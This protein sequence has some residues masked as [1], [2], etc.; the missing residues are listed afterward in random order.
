[1][2]SS[3]SNESPETYH[4]QYTHNVIAWDLVA[5]CWQGGKRIKETGELRLPKLRDQDQDEYDA[6]LSRAVFFGA[7]SRTAEA[8]AG[9]MTRKM[10]LID[11]PGGEGTAENERLIGNVTMRGDSL[12]DFVNMVLD[13][14][15]TTGRSGSLVDW[16]EAE[17][18]P[19]VSH[20]RERDLL[21]WAIDR[22]GSKEQLCFVCLREQDYRFTN[23]TVSEM[24]II[25]R[26]WIDPTDQKV[27]FDVW[28]ET[29]DSTDESFKQTVPDTV[30]TRRGEALT[31]IPFVFHNASHLGPE[32]GQI[33]L[34]DIA[35][36]NISHYQLTADLKNALHI[37]GQPTPFATGVSGDDGEDLYLG[38]TK[39]WTISDPAATVG[40]LEMTG[41]S[42]GALSADI[43][44]TE[45]QMAV[46]G[47]RLLFDAPGGEAE[48]FETVQLRASSETAALVRIATHQSATISEV[49]Q[50]LFWWRGTEAKHRDVKASLVLNHDFST[51]QMSPTMLSALTASLSTNAISNELYFYNL[52][53]GELVPEGHDLKAELAAI[54]Q[55]PVMTPPVAT[56]DLDDDDDDDDEKAAKKKA[57]EDES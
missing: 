8:L 36:L 26:Y 12:L 25:R 55:R 10:P 46:L 45:R 28:E 13:K 6:Y 41:E 57:E 16:S 56:I 7:T 4:P 29:D 3:A 35:Q 2:S 1:M 54:Q 18:R 17:A 11:V 44:N 51:A 20:Y 19:Y 32:V 39:A 52:Q 23:F 15:V 5:D 50:W 24:K 42:L 27:H 43:S 40:F 30:M 14:A 9:M 21:N 53:K 34:Y 49:L 47:A 48:A 22:E 31:A 37:A 38:T 33:T